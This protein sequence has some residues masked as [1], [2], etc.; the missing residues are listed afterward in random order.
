MRLHSPHWLIS[1]LVLFLT[2]SNVLYTQGHAY[3]HRGHGLS[4]ATVLMTDRS[5]LPRVI[6]S[7]L[8]YVDAASHASHINDA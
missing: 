7:E 5:R 2:E 8:S 1:A 3:M 6:H 4:F